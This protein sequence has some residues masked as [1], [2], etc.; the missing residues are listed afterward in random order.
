[1]V[2]AMDALAVEILSHKTLA[3]DQKLCPDV[4]SHRQGRMPKA[5]RMADV[6]FSPKV[7]LFCEVLQKKARP[8]V[9]KHWREQIIRLYHQLTHSGQ[10]DTVKKVST[11]YYWPNLKN[12]VSSF[13]T[14]CQNCQ[15]VKPYKT[16]RPER[17]NIPVPDQRFTHIQVD[18][19][20]PLPP[21]E[22]H[23]YLLTILD[24]T[25]RWIEAL[26]LTEA[27]SENCA[28]AFIRG[29][30]KHFGLPRIVTSDNGNTFVAQLWKD[31]N[32]TLGIEV[33]YTPPHTIPAHWG[34]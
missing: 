32:Q 8:L 6:E 28:R 17:G 9:P 2:A 29:W 24:R 16:I 5:V 25:S 4:A 12:D 18:I 27:T 22:G 14:R 11:S 31:L 20:G 23:R 7:T 13:V 30:I 26:P 10:K 3:A 34:V 1:M 21:S 33:A 19:V 15:A